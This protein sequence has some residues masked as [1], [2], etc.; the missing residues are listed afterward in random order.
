MGEDNLL[1]IIEA[2]NKKPLKNIP[3]PDEAS[4]NQI[5]KSPRRATAVRAAASA[6]PI[7]RSEIIVRRNADFEYAS[8]LEVPYKNVALQDVVSGIE[9][10]AEHGPGYYH[11]EMPARELEIDAEYMYARFISLTGHPNGVSAERLT[12]VCKYERISPEQILFLDLETTGLSGTPVFLIGTME[13]QAAGFVFKQ[14]LA[15]K[16]SEEISILSAFSER[17]ASVRLVITFNGKSFDMPFLNSR[18]LAHGMAMPQPDYHLDVLQE[19]RKAYKRDLPN[20]KLQTIERH[21]CGREREDDIPGAEIPN[22][23]NEYVRTG[24]AY[25][26]QSI[27][28]HNLYDI[29]TM[30]DILGR[31]WRNK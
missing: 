8:P 16:Y 20:C 1:G 5:K 29:L 27:L 17:M 9:C 19:A 13:C 24:N 6:S 2:L 18:A 31:M 14:Y 3:S 10:L 28:T 23:Y 4:S 12:K 22:A 25:K 21:I 15:R 26:M 11:I 30:A 7:T